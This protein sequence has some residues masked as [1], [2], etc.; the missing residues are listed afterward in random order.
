[1]RDQGD[2]SW[3]YAHAAADYLQ[4]TNRI[5]VQ[6]SA[7]DIAVTYNKRRWP[8]FLR[9]IYGSVVPETGFIRSAIWDISEIGYCPEE[10]FPS[11]TW[12]K[13]IMIGENKGQTIQMPLLK[14]VKEITD[15]VANIKK[16]IYLI[17]NDLPFV[18]EFKDMTHEQFYDAVFV[19]STGNVLDE[20]RSASCD[21]HRKPFSKEIGSIMMNFKNSNSFA[22]MNQVLDSK[23]PLTVDYFYGFLNNIDS[24]KKTV[25]ELHTTLLMG[26]RFNEASQECQYLIKNSYG[27]DCAEYDKRH[28][29]EAGYVWVGESSLYDAMTSFVYVSESHD[30]TTQTASQIQD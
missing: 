19:N 15:M 3:C 6:I 8:R 9:W 29:C 13:R 24:Y 7:A 21:A 26:R 1:M 17:P 25:G 23:N 18:Y 30:V 27:P 20:I 28:T 12:T 5:Q 2:I 10:Y 16:G 14:A 22:Q 11:D 4:F